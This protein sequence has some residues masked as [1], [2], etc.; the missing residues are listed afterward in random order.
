MSAVKN[1]LSGYA[2]KF[3]M[4]SLNA[5]ADIIFLALPIN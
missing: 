2:N 5:V 1:M 4:P 3:L